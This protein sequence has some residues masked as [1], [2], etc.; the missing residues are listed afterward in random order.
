MSGENSL[1]NRF[2][3]FDNSRCIRKDGSM[4]NT[5]PAAAPA[6]AAKPAKPAKAAKPTKPAKAAKPAKPAAPKKPVDPA[7][8]TAKKAK[9]ATVKVAKKAVAKKGDTGQGERLTGAKR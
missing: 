2:V 1:A 9:K 8:A 5:T 7:K 4:T 3:Y 6:K